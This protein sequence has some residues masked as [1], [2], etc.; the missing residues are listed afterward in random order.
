MSENLTL[1]GVPVIGED[2]Q[3]VKATK[4]DIEQKRVLAAVHAG[5]TEDEWPVWLSWATWGQGSGYEEPSEELKAKAREL[6]RR[7]P[8]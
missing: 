5:L 7:E 6:A 4:E 2:G 1:F 8:A 3:P